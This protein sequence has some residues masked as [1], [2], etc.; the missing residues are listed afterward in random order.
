M[1]I[2]KQIGGHVHTGKLIV[3]LVLYNFLFP[4]VF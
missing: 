3:L 4:L 1:E 2:L